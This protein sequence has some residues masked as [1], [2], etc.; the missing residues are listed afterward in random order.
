MFVFHSL[1]F[2]LKMQLWNH[3]TSRGLTFS[4]FGSFDLSL[5][6]SVYLN[7]FI[8]MSFSL[9]I[10]YFRN[11]TCESPTCENSIWSTKWCTPTYTCWRVRLPVESVIHP[12]TCDGVLALQLVAWITLE[13]HAVA[14]L[15]TVPVPRTI[16]RYTW[17][18]A[19]RCCCGWK[20]VKQRIESDNDMPLGRW[21]QSIRV[22]TQQHYH[23]PQLQYKEVKTHMY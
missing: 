1:H 7:F 17:V 14:G 9:S 4:F 21:T 2:R 23:C 15:L 3:C 18:I 12:Y 11:T 20:F 13:R 16:Y 5:A 19:G 6:L 8:Y 10:Q 22:R